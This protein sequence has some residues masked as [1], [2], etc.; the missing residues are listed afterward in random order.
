MVSKAEDR[1]MSRRMEERW[2]YWA[3]A[4]KMDK[5]ENAVCAEWRV[6]N[7][8]SRAVNTLLEYRV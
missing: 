2:L 6:M 5:C 3:V 8:D 1:S 4:M 7:L